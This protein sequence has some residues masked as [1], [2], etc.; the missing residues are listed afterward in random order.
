MESMNHTSNLSVLSLG[1]VHGVRDPEGIEHSYI[2]VVLYLQSHRSMLNFFTFIS[3]CPFF[4][5][6]GFLLVDANK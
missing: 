5:G 1:N 6:E 3:T 4:W 2:H